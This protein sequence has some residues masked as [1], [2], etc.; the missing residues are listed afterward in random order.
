M[1]GALAKGRKGHGKTKKVNIAGDRPAPRGRRKV[2]TP[3]T[4]TVPSQ[5]T[6]LNIAEAVF[7][8]GDGNGARAAGG[9]SSFEGGGACGPLTPT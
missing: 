2:E 9:D 4:S 1:K 3:V 5:V 6:F 7:G 8:E